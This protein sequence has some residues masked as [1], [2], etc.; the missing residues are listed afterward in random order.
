MRASSVLR[1]GL[2]GLLLMAPAAPLYAQ[3]GVRDLTGRAVTPVDSS[4]AATVLLFTAV[5][6][7]VSDR[8]APAVRRD[9]RP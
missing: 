5:E 4:A 8:Y 1:L 6:C 7:H 3:T 2:V 9:I